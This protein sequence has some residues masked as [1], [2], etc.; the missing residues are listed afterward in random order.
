MRV[1]QGFGRISC[2]SSA[3]VS[4]GSREPCAPHQRGGRAAKT[5]TFA[6]FRLLLPYFRPTSNRPDLSQRARP[7]IAGAARAILSPS[8]AR[9][10]SAAS[11][12]RLLARAANTS[13]P[14][15]GGSR[16]HSRK[17]KKSLETYSLF[18]PNQARNKYPSGRPPTGASISRRQ[19]ALRRQPPGPP[20]A[21][22]PH[23]QLHAAPRH[24]CRAHARTRGNSTLTRCGCN[25]PA[26]IFTALETP[27]KRK[28]RAEARPFILWHKALLTEGP[29]FPIG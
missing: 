5:P 11:A 8:K 14:A 21:N 27:I 25:C 18:V 26:D 29:R 24:G 19:A 16:R 20:R 12:V 17:R 10:I 6:Y 9:R 4:I 1:A 22:S 23:K 2:G 3:F 13:P 7:T 28:G 15:A